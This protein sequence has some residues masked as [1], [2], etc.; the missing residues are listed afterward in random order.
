[1]PV[2][3]AAGASSVYSFAMHLP[4]SAW[5]HNLARS[6]TVE[7][8]GLVSVFSVFTRIY[9]SSTLSVASEPGAASSVRVAQFTRFGSVLSILSACRLWCMYYIASMFG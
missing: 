6:S 5:M 1:M 3:E 7:V 4:V 9:L 8:L 2:S